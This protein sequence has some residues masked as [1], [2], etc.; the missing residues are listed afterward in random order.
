MHRDGEQDTGGRSWH[1]APTGTG[2]GTTGSILG[3]WLNPGETVTWTWSADGE[4]VVGYTINTPLD[5]LDDKLESK[6]ETKR[7]IG[8]STGE[9]L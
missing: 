1:S 8:Y 3:V 7:T 2:R 4:N 5:T 6:I 9:T